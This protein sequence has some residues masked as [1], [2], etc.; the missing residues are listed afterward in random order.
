MYSVCR[1]YGHEPLDNN[2]TRVKITPTFTGHW[3]YQLFNSLQM[4]MWQVVLAP[5]HQWMWHGS[6]QYYIARMLWQY[7]WHLLT[8]PWLNFDT[9][10]RQSK[11]DRRLN[12]LLSCFWYIS[13]WY[14]FA[15]F[16]THFI[17]FI[18]Y[19][20]YSIINHIIWYTFESIKVYL[21]HFWVY[22]KW[23]KNKVSNFDRLKF[24]SKFH[25]SVS[26]WTRP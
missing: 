6:D 18:F 25:Q 24:V 17:R 1:T 11:L 4:Q 15:P 26:S 3:V 19:L 20:W 10:L 13:I 8:L 23:I 14:F 5:M 7:D 12:S 9:L 21:I 2:N 22:Q 16:H